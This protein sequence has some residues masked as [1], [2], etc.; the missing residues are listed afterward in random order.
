MNK[1]YKDSEREKVVSRLVKLSAVVIM[2]MVWILIDKGNIY[3]QNLPQGAETLKTKVLQDSPSAQLRLAED[4]GG[5]RDGGLPVDDG[6]DEFVTRPNPVVTELVFDF[7]FT[8]KMGVP[9]QVVDP[10]GRLVAQGTFE[11][12]INTQSID[13]SRFKE[14]MY[15]VRL[16]IG[17]KV[18][19]RKILKR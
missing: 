8:V 17:E 11:P 9:Y 7:E 12:G 19:V 6:G 16:Q 2:V 14:G 5:G 15:L 13:F 18:A 10:L 3:G 4:D 1:I